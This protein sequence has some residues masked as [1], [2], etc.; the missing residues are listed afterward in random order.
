MVLCFSQK[1][2]K[3]KVGISDNFFTTVHSDI[4]NIQYIAQIGNL[5]KHF[6]LQYIA[7]SAAELWR[8]VCDYCPAKS[9]GRFR[10]TTRSHDDRDFR[11]RWWV[12]TQS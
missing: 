8:T 3:T 6:V 7:Y 9:L 4:F 12:Y 11:M 5:L 10:P 1:K 2:K